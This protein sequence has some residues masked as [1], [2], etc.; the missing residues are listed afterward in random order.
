MTIPDLR[1]SDPSI[2]D[3]YKDILLDGLLAD[4]GM[5]SFADVLDETKV[6]Q[7]KAYVISLANEA[8]ALQEGIEVPQPAPAAAAPVEEAPAP[9]A[10]T[11][12]APVPAPSDDT[13]APA[14]AADAPEEAAAPDTSTGTD[15]P[16]LPDAP[17]QEQ[18][19][20]PEAASD[21][22]EADA[23]PVVTPGESPDPAAAP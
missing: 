21:T 13:P 19:A 23:A 12:E 14:P 22:P 16:A 7:V 11:E 17:A 3:S 5:A 6:E 20:D 8:Y 2:Y 4:N 1:A 10:P 18:S 9:A 15:T